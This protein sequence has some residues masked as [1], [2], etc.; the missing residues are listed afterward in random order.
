[1]RILGTMVG[2][3]GGQTDDSDGQVWGTICDGMG[4]EQWMRCSYLIDYDDDIVIVLL[5]VVIFVGVLIIFIYLFTMNMTI[6]LVV[7]LII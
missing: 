4:E 6:L 5:L 7:L 3:C 1:M 2:G